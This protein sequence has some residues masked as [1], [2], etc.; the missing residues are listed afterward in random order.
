M[1]FCYYVGSYTLKRP[2]VNMNNMAVWKSHVDANEFHTIVL[3][4]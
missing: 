1:S 4:N 3:C 2:T